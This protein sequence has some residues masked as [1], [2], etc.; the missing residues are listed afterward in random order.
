MSL[1]IYFDVIL[2]NRECVLWGLNSRSPVAE[3]KVVVKWQRR[4]ADGH[5]ESLQ[6]EWWLSQGARAYVPTDLLPSQ[7]V[8]RRECVTGCVCMH[9][10]VCACGEYDETP[11]WCVSVETKSAGASFA[12]DVAI[13]YITTQ[14]SFWRKS[15]TSGRLEGHAALVRKITQ[16]P[17]SGM[18]V[19]PDFYIRSPWIK[20]WVSSAVSWWH[21]VNCFRSRWWQSELPGD[22]RG[23]THTTLVRQN[24]LSLFGS[25]L[26]YVR[27]L[28]LKRNLGNIV[29]SQHW[30]ITQTSMNRAGQLLEDNGLI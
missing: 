20:H 11:V 4:W 29:C 6:T 1:L 25:K 8:Q 14:D 13:S 18:R 3:F 22:R 17:L 30:K 19:K 21:G 7:P 9:V 12:A 27:L 15:W 5:G 16:D 10:C 24:K 2:G 28:Y 23:P 26:T